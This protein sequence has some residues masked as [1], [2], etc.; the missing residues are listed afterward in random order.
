MRPWI[1]DRLGE[2]YE[3]FCA[4]VSDTELRELV[5]RRWQRGMTR[6][7]SDRNTAERR[8]FDYVYRRL[9]RGWG[10]Q[11]PATTFRYPTLYLEGN[12]DYHIPSAE[13]LRLNEDVFDGE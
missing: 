1:T 8:Y 9:T 7:L 2:S 11:Q 12:P 10:Y 6:Y 13:T 4:R 5:G 3:D